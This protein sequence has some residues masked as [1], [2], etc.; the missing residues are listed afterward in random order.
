M[1]TEDN[2]R[3]QVLDLIEAYGGQAEMARYFHGLGYSMTRAAVGMWARRGSIGHAAA[4]IL[5]R[6]GRGKAAR[7]FRIEDVCREEAER[8]RR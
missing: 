5:F 8:R 2:R 4:L 6:D 3:A 1:T 7:G